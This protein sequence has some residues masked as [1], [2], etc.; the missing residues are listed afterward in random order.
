M[1]KALL[2]QDA[3]LRSYIQMWVVMVVVLVLEVLSGLVSSR[4][5]YICIV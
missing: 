2:L 3:Q 4:S 5:S 1:F